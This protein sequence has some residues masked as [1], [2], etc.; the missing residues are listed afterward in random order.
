M[1]VGSRPRINKAPF[2]RAKEKGA[3]NIGVEVNTGCSNA[4]LFCAV[5]APPQMSFMPAPLFMAVANTVG[6]MDL[7]LSFITQRTDISLYRWGR[8]NLSHLFE[9]SQ[10]IYEEQ[11]M[12]NALLFCCGPGDS[13]VVL[14]AA[15]GM[16]QLG[17]RA[18]EL[19]LHLIYKQFKGAQLDGRLER[20]AKRAASLIKLFN[21]SLISLKGACGDEDD[22]EYGIFSMDSVK[23]FFTNMVLPLLSSSLQKEYG[24]EITEVY[25]GST[26]RVGIVEVEDDIFPDTAYK[27]NHLPVCKNYCGSMSPAFMIVYPDGSYSLEERGKLPREKGSILQP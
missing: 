7:K 8:F 26:N 21:P 13:S 23:R 15:E 9:A 25:R 3:R 22:P 11:C 20:H 24:E 10:N 17:F 27:N 2:L 5:H 16:N 14:A 6:E 18:E 4:C 19:S 12:A 1:L